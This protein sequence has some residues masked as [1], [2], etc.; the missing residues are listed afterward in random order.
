MHALLF[1]ESD[2]LMQLIKCGANLTDFL[3]L[4][5]SIELKLFLIELDAGG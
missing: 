2:K 4:F 3:G 1:G 5:V